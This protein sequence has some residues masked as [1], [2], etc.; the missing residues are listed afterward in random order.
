MRFAA[1]LRNWSLGLATASL[2][3]AGAAWAQPPASTQQ[4]TMQQSWNLTGANARLEQKLDTANAHRGQVIEA[5]LNSSART[6]NGMRLDRGTILWGEVDEVQAS[7]NGS[8]SVLSVVFTKA[9]LKDGRT[10]PVKV[11]V[12]GVYPSDEA[13]LAV[14]GSQTIPPAPQH[15]NSQER[16]DQEPG[17]LHDISLHSAVQNHNSGTFRDSRGNLKLNAGTFLQVGIAP[18]NASSRG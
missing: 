7:T 13:Q 14:T 9:Q 4:N 6:A 17:L 16:V 3:C 2:L 11:T 5:K 12:L 18:Q 1:S 10:I 8:P 15:I